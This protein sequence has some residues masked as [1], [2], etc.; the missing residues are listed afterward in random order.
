[1]RVSVRWNEVTDRLRAISRASTP[2]EI[3]AFAQHVDVDELTLRNALEGRSRLA[4]IK[5]ITSLVR[6]GVDAN[7]LLTGDVDPVL[8]RRMLEA[9]RDE[10]QQMV[11]QLVA[12]LSRGADEEYLRLSNSD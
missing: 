5:V 6:H 12:G 4:A 9:E 3:R 8:Y 10:V 1:M 2:D 7:Y 11:K